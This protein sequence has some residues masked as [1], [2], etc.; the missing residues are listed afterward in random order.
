M[1]VWDFCR[2]SKVAFSE[3]DAGPGKK[4]VAF[5]FPKEWGSG[6]SSGIVFVFDEAQVLQRRNGLPG[7]QR[8]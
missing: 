6:G 3:A 1:Q 5:G 2:N 8:Q 4:D 7:L